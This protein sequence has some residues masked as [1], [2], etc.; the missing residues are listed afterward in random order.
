MWR[1]EKRETRAKAFWWRTSLR[2]CW[3]GFHFRLNSQPSPSSCPAPCAVS[4]LGLADR[5]LHPVS[6]CVLRCRESWL[7]AGPG[8][9]S[10]SWRSNSKCV[11]LVYSSR[12]S[13]CLASAL[14]LLTWKTWCVKLRNLGDTSAAFLYF[15]IFRAKITCSTN[16]RDLWASFHTGS[17]S[18]WFVPSNALSCWQTCFWSLARWVSTFPP[19]TAWSFSLFTWTNLPL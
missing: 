4:G 16:C 14:H 15:G 9:A 19:G 11:P 8:P 12:A 17:A 7:H 10:V 13:P 2:W 5:C 3:P 6:F 1:A 18:A